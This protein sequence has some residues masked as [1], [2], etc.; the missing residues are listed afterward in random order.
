MRRILITLILLLGFALPVHAAEPVVAQV[1]IVGEIDGSTV[2]SV[3]GSLE[4]AKE[5]KATQLDIRINSPGGNI[6]DGLEVIRLI[7]ASGLPTVCTVDTSAASMAAV[8]L[9]SSACGERVVNASSLI[10]FHDSASEMRGNE[11]MMG[12]RL[13]MLQVMNQAI[14]NIVAP[15]IGMTPAQYLRLVVDEGRE[16]WFLG[17]DAVKNGIADRVISLPEPAQ[18]KH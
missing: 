4:K 15:R 18:A 8:I 16:L 6:G 3:H 10:M 13:G 11:R 12:N 9:E 1:D 5:A 7:R 14:A 17:A 2:D